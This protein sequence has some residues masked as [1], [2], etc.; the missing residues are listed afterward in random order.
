MHENHPPRC[1]ATTRWLLARAGLFVLLIV[2][3]FGIDRAART[4]FRD[5]D[6]PTVANVVSTGT[7]VLALRLP[8][9]SSIIQDEITVSIASDDGQIKA[10]R[11]I[12][13]SPEPGRAIWY[14]T[15]I[16]LTPAQWQPVE[17]LRQTWCTAPPAFAPAHAQEPV[18]DLGLRCRETR[19]DIEAIRVQ[20]PQRELPPALATLIDTVPLPPPFD[21]LT[22]TPRHGSAPMHVAV[23]QQAGHERWHR[24]PC[25]GSC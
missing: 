9:T 19:F 2:L 17:R 13:H 16:P 15:G 10:V 20:I 23:P 3:V 1:D 25:S 18:Y 7:R 4:I 21:R 14:S 5:A 11:A 22:P 6:H 12:N 24:K 8:V